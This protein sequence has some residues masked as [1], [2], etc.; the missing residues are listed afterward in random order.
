MKVR[1]WYALPVFLLLLTFLETKAQTE[2]AEDN[3]NAR[4]IQ[5]YSFYLKQKMSLE[6]ITGRFPQL[7]DYVVSTMVEWNRE[8]LPSV[9]TIDSMLSAGLNAEWQKT[10]NDLYEKF[11][12]ADYSSV[13]E[14]DAKLFIDVVNDR[15]SGHIQ[16]PVLETLLYWNPEYRKF[17]EKEFADGYISTFPVERKHGNV[18]VNIKLVYPRSWK[19]LDGNKKANI[20]QTFISEYGL[21]D[22]ELCLII[23]KSKSNYTQDKIKQ[24]LTQESLLKNQPSASKVLGYTS[25]LSIDNC[26]AAAITVSQDKEM[27][28]LKK[29]LRI[30][31]TYTTFYKNVKIVLLFTISSQKPDELD[32]KYQKYKKL[33]K[34]I[35]DNTVILSQWGQ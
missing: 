35:V 8:F 26:D 7:K 28:S 24:L 1:H 27:E 18:P 21:G 19:A 25:G 9:L 2:Q 12:R 20:I 33:I 3:E 22:V 30:N 5:A 32:F 4:M 23:E 34:R 17:P 6:F 15:T 13:T 29:I 11:I 14:A 10:K 31:E 16:S